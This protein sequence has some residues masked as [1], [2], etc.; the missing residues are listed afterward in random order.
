MRRGLALMFAAIVGFAL[1][2]PVGDAA[3]QRRGRERLNMY[4]AL[5]NAEQLGQLTEQGFDI[6]AERA[7]GTNLKVDLVLTNQQRAKLAQQGIR[8]KL[9][10]VKGGQ[11][12]QQFA[13]AQAENGFDVWR[14]WDEPGGFSDQ[15]Y[16]IARE[17]PQIAKLVNIGTTIQGREM[18]ALKITQGARGQRDGSRPAVLYSATQHARE[19]IAAEVDRRLM[20]YL[21]DGWRANDR[22]IRNLLKETELWFVPVANPDGYQYTFDTDRLWRKNL[23]DNNGDGEITVGDGIDLNRNYPN[24]F[25]YDEEG[26]S[27]I[28]S[29]ETYRGTGPVSEP[30]TI[31]PSA[32]GC[33]TRRAGRSARRPRT[34]RSTS[35]SPAT[36]TSPRSMTSTRG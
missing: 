13:A 30:E 34:T 6:N 4:T 18:L 32:S 7:D 19:W 25:K 16:E 36:S 3:E 1:M 28:P 26:S 29:S 23:R 10:R 8:T 24:H 35:H 14:S 20:N 12:V 11:T 2:A 17:N 33:F 27:S 31:T 15:M 5:V 22:E 21:V 9:T